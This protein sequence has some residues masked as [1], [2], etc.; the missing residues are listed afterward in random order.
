MLTDASQH[1]AFH[2]GATH[3][4]SVHC[5]SGEL[6]DVRAAQ[7]LN[8][9]GDANDDGLLYRGN[10]PTHCLSWYGAKPRCSQF[11]A[12]LLSLQVRAGSWM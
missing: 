11:R 1:A 3:R 12:A 6:V 10:V 5:L 8:L 7:D 4:M 9:V 2:R